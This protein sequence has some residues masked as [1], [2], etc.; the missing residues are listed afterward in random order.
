ME[1]R[2]GRLCRDLPPEGTPGER[3]TGSAPRLG[4]GLVWLGHKD[5]GGGRRGWWQ[6]DL[7]G[8]D[9]G[10]QLQRDAWVF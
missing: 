5:Q 6:G 2:R 9:C 7:G 8:S 4:T 1:P 3:P 10:L